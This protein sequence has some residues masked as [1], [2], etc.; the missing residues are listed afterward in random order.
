[1]IN[2]IKPVYVDFSVPEQ[3]LAVVRQEMAEGHPLP[4]EVTI[5]GTQEIVNGTLSFVDNSVDPNTGTIELK[6]LFANTD[7]RLW[8][9][10]FVDSRLTLREIPNAVMVPSQAIQSGQD[11]SYVFVIGPKM[12]ASMRPVVLGDSI[13]GDTVIERGLSGGETVVTDG[14]VRLIPGATVTIKS[15]LAPEQ[16]AAS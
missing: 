13:G 2:Q 16:K 11:G 10:Q 1:V 6:G 5:P 9:G 12:K 15:G 4:V 8:P 7:E 14:Q 3:D